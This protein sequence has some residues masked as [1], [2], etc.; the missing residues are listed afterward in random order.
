[1]CVCLNAMV[2][3]LS[4]I[5]TLLCHFVILTSLAVFLYKFSLMN[6]PAITNAADN[7]YLFLLFAVKGDS[8]PN[9]KYVL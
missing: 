2:G 5:A 6:M 4:G 9:D 7:I 8:N 3:M 1:M